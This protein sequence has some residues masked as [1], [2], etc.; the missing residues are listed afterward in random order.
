MNYAGLEISGFTDFG[1][2]AGVVSVADSLFQ[3]N[4]AWGVSGGLAVENYCSAVVSN[5]TFRNNSATHSAGG[6]QVLLS[7]VKDCFL[8]QR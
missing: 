6:L 4:A 1:V 2:F 3:N 5:V 8:E 7:D